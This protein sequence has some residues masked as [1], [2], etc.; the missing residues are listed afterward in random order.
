MGDGTNLLRMLEPAVRPG[1]ASGPTA[2]PTAPIESRAF[3]SLLEE[4]RA[5]AAREE[6]QAGDAGSAERGPASDGS[7]SGAHAPMRQLAQL[8]RIENPGVFRLIGG[9]QAGGMQDG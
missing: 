7:G 8:D 5:S 2:R 4:A 1:S 9:E 6:T 3:E